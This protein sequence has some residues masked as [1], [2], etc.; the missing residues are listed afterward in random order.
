LARALAATVLLAMLA[1]VA[2]AS[3]AP[4]LPLLL[5]LLYSAL[6]AV[7]LFVAVVVAALAL[8]T[9]YQF[10][11]RKGGTDPQWFWFSAEPPGLVQLR[12]QARKEI[13]ATED[14]AP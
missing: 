8:L 3:L 7:A 1:G 5:V 10:V 6:G 14:R 12:E 13:Q 9:V 4:K 11:L 2:G